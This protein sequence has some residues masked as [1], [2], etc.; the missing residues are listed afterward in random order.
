[1]DNRDSQIRKQSCQVQVLITECLYWNWFLLQWIFLCQSV[2]WGYLTKWS[3]V[4]T[5]RYLLFLPVLGSTELIV[6]CKLKQNPGFI[7][8]IQ[9]GDEFRGHN[10]VPF[11]F[12]LDVFGEPTTEAV[13]MQT[14]PTLP[15]HL[16]TLFNH[17]HFAFLLNFLPL[18]FAELLNTK[19]HEA[20]LRAR[21]G[22]GWCSLGCKGIFHHPWGP[23]T[24]ANARFETLVLP[25]LDMKL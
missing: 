6:S 10:L 4:T 16:R 19:H 5:H 21:T 1:M 17:Y 22:D 7:N 9:N 18:L 12:L 3:S 24:F 23:N 2:F 15:I 8:C 11:L 13:C 25:L 20:A 14:L